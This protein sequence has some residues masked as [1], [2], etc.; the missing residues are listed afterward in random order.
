MNQEK[1]LDISWET[2][3]KIG[4]AILIFYILFLIRDLIVWFIF[5][6]IISLLFDPVIDFL[7]RKKVPRVLG[8]ALVYLLVFGIFGLLIY[9]VAPGFVSEIQKFMQNFPQ[10]FERIAPVLKN[11]KIPAFADLESFTGVLQNTL[12]K[13][14]ENF[15]N[16]LSVIFGG[17]SA[18]IFV[19]SAAFFL[20]L[21]ERGIERVLAA[22]S[23]RKYE[24]Y[25]AD[26]WAKCQKK[27]SGWFV[28]RILSSLFVGVVSFLVFK[29]FKIDFSFSLG[30]L[31]G[32]TN[33]IP[34]IGPIVAGVVI[35]AMVA[36]TSLSKAIFVLL[37][38]TI[39]QQIEGNIISPILS[40]KF[41]GL[42]PVLVLIS[43]A[44]GG[45][46]W[47][48]MGA[49]LVIPLVGIIYEFLRDFLKKKK[50]EKPVV[51]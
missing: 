38:F 45:K 46:L 17:I 15:F 44:V 4:I 28:S 3:L 39:L 48:I 33:F 42:P 10:Y 22:L 19:I 24:A 18:T 20:S 49:I 29:L 5:A 6:L 26:L 36:M 13:A 34:I 30:F 11:L 35:F 12:A 32:I 23:P 43:L 37:A 7:Q 21:E 40:R 2:I 9:A 47:G 27:V 50:A 16:A 8:S 31:A 25:V 51:L 41:I 1:I 14:G